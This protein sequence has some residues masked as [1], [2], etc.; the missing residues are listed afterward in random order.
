MKPPPK[1]R[2][3]NSHIYV[4]PIMSCALRGVPIRMGGTMNGPACSPSRVR[5]A[6]RV[7]RD[8]AAPK[9][10]GGLAIEFPRGARKS[11]R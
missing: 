8:L 11:D 9:F 4:D 2:S 7:G 5:S 3:R 6:S 10:S 1:K